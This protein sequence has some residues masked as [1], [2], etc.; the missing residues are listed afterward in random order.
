MGGGRRGNILQLRNILLTMLLG[1]LWHGAS[2]T[3]VIWGGLHGL[4]LVIN[5][6][7]HNVKE[8]LGI[9]LEQSAW[10]SNWLSRIFTLLIVSSLWVVFRAENM[11]VALTILKSMFGMNYS[12]E[13]L[14]SRAEALSGGI[15]HNTDRLI[16]CLILVWFAPN[17]QQFMSRFVPESYNVNQKTNH[18]KNKLQWAPN[19]Y[20]A[21][22]IGILLVSS[23]LN[24]T[25]INE[26]L[27]FQF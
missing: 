15:Q 27:Y 9:D 22:F 19:I 10:W 23:I 18:S 1:G 26:F 7:W 11:G 4:C 3:F 16:A 12:L 17:T 5:H 21:L 14:L 6:L 8:K 13:A 20:W 24:L 25:R 2:W